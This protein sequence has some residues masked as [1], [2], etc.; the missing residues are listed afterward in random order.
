[1][2]AVFELVVFFP[3]LPYRL[4]AT[5]GQID[6]GRSG[7]ATVGRMHDYCFTLSETQVCLFGV[8]RRRTSVATPQRGIAANIEICEQY[9]GQN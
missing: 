1:M 9:F 5:C 6:M 8:G 7:L 2:V 4:R 3:F